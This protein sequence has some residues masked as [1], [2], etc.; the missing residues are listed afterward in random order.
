MGGL[1]IA[2]CLT[3]AVIVFFMW[4]VQKQLETLESSKLPET[5]STDFIT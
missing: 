5:A 3:S 4:F 1:F 2:G